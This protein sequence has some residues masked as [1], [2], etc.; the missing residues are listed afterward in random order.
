MVVITPSS[1]PKVVPGPQPVLIML[2]RQLT[3]RAKSPNHCSSQ[4]VPR[5][6]LSTLSMPGLRGGLAPIIL[7][8]LRRAH[9]AEPPSS[10]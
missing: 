1:G 8:T 5:I 9:F 3:M 6:L 7:L 10:V 2:R 4:G